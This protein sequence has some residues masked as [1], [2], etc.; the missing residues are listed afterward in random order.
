MPRFW[1][2]IPS[3]PLLPRKEVLLGKKSNRW[4]TG[5]QLSFIKNIGPLLGRDFYLR[6]ATFGVIPRLT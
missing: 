5:E 1:T 3:Q 6:I 2:K 4:P